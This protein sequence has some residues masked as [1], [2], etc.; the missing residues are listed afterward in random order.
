[1]KFYVGLHH[2]STAQ[3]FERC[4]VS[5][6][7]IRKRKSDFK[8]AEWIIDSGAFTE[9]KDHGHYR[10][11]PQEYAEE[12]L[13][14]SKCGN[15]VAAVSQDYMCEPFIVARTGLSTQEHQRLTIAR[16]D[17]LVA[18]VG[19]AAYVM[20]VL[21]GYWPDEYLTHLGAYGKR[22]KRGS[23]VG[24]GSVCKRNANVAAIE[25][26]VVTISRA[27][28]DL[29]LHGFGVKTTALKSSL[30]MGSLYSADSSAWSYA[31]RMRGGDRH[32]WHEAQRFVEKIEK[33][34]VVKRHFQT[35]FL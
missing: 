34:R 17:A 10:T 8:V 28:P 21:Q 14:W 3:H 4:M 9:L 11:E 27:R 30:V 33:Q 35:F 15:M 26:V 19:R 13:R 32:S 29:R 20:P 31:A 24:V 18:S 1:M 7:T 23:W 12:I 2:P 6:K 25:A 16:Y 5:V 22:L